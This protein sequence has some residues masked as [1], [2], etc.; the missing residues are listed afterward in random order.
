MKVKVAIL[1]SGESDITGYVYPPELLKK[2]VEKFNKRHKDIPAFGCIYDDVE[3]VGIPDYRISH[4]IDEVKFTEHG[5]EAEI[6]ILD[7]PYGKIVK[8][9]IELSLDPDT[10]LSVGFTPSMT[11]TVNSD[12]VVDDITLY[13]IH[14]SKNA[15]PVTL[16]D[17]KSLD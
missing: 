13:S 15:T 9:L 6:T 3:G 16:V 12:N 5:L 11:G 8:A 2:A 1:N 10:D 4:R 7:T 17:D 14:V